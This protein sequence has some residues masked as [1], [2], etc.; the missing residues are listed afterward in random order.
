MQGKHS[1][2]NSNRLTIR[3]SDS[4]I[5]MRDPL[6]P[7]ICGDILTVD[8]NDHTITRETMPEALVD[9][10]LGGRG[11]NVGYL[12]AHL[13]TGTDPMGPGN[14]LVFSCGLLT[15]TRAPTAP[16]LHINALSPLTGL[17]GSSN[18][19]GYAGAWL[20]STGIVSLVI[21]GQAPAPVYLHISERDVEIRDAAPL[22]G[23]GCLRHPGQHRRR[24]G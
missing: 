22:L 19:G 7:V 17:I 5:A 3:W 6:H 4:Q 12:F 1:W 9:R 10:Y 8:L 14:M 11:F 23:A 20:R 13:P 18:V 21:R 24:P 15:G 2:I 16:R